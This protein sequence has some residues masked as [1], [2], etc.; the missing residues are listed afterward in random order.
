MKIVRDLIKKF[1][2]SQGFRLVDKRDY[3]HV[4]PFLYR[5]IRK[6]R[7]F[8]FIQIGANDGV[9]FDPIHPFVTKY[10]NTKVSIRGIAIEPMADAYQQLCRSY[11]QFPNILTVKAAIHNSEKEMTLYK[12]DPEKLDQLP[13][14]S[15]GIA[16]F[17]PDHHKRSGTPRECIVTEK[18]SCIS[19][20]ELLNK[21]KITSIDL[22]QMDTE[23]YDAEI[24]LNFDFERIRPKIIRFEHG[25]QF[26]T[27]SREKFTEVVRILNKNGYQVI[28][29]QSDATAYQ[30]FD[31]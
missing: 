16:S 3:F 27:M 24:I 20:S 5:Q 12:V 4:E 29:E 28:T 23:G 21:H 2:E 26:G 22:L 6:N 18:V 25:L 11:S 19:F 7:S 14:G 15:R 10:S 13:E 1:L 30:P 8:F 17:D 9:S 31:F